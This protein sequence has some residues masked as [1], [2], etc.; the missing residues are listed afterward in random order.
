M[1]PLNFTASVQ[2]RPCHFHDETERSVC[3]QYEIIQTE[4]GAAACLETNRSPALGPRRGARPAAASI[5]AH[6]SSFAEL[7]VLLELQ[8]FARSLWRAHST[9]VLHHSIFCSML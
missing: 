8:P 6:L 5:V 7:G 2:L 3:R 1:R 4:C 9:R